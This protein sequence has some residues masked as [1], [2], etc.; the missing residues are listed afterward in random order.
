[1]HSSREP[2]GL[3][4]DSSLCLFISNEAETYCVIKN[5]DFLFDAFGS[6]KTHISQSSFLS[7]FVLC[8][9]GNSIFISFAKRLTSLT[10]LGHDTMIRARKIERYSI[11]K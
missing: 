5:V 3:E 11:A 4:S 10:Y 8:F 1:M 6:W 7:C 2:W 9:L